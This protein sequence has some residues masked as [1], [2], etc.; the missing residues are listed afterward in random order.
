[1]SESTAKAVGSVCRSERFGF[2]L[3]EDGTVSAQ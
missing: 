2:G 3:H 1:M